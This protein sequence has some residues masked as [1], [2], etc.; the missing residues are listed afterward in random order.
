MPSEILASIAHAA[1]EDWD[2]VQEE[3][4][5]FQNPEVVNGSLALRQP[6]LV[7]LVWKT[8]D[9][10][11]YNNIVFFI[12]ESFTLLSFFLYDFRMSQLEK[13]EKSGTSLPIATF[14]YA[15]NPYSIFSFGINSIAVTSSLVTCWIFIAITADLTAFASVLCAIGCYTHIYPGYVFL[16]V[17]CQIRGNFVRTCFA[18]STFVGTLGSLLALSYVVAGYN[19]DFIF[20]SY[21]SNVFALNTTPNMGVFWYMYVEMF[22]HFNT[23]FVWTMQL[24][25][26]ATCIGL[27]LR[28]YKDP[29][30]LALAL[31]MSTGILR[32]YNSIAELG[33]SL[34]LAS[35]WHHLIK[36]YKSTVLS[37]S[38]LFIS[39]I[40]SP[41]FHFTWLRTAT[42]NANFYFSAAL[43]HA[44]GRVEI[45]A[46]GMRAYLKYDFR[47]KFGPDPR[48]S[49]G[50]R[51]VAKVNT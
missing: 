19:W 13:V 28:F 1:N 4:A 40:L 44:L 48:L 10:L 32:P 20:H 11:N 22:D 3:I 50:V 31:N 47:K 45:V 18:V 41:L 25:I 23:F 2:R 5:L 16:A 38:F 27:S 46:R 43:I 51:L 26:F 6:P 33:C 8:L 14:V 39:L 7:L 42:S 29:L 12:C 34:A 17:L 24:I 21:L 36:F 49:N 35:Q 37:V 30:F 9:Q 15:V